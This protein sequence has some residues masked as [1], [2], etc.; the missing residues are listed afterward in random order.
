MNKTRAFTKE[1]VATN[2]SYNPTSNR[3]R[4]AVACS[5]APWPMVALGDLCDLIRGVVY[6][7][8]DE[9]RDNGKKILRANNIDVDGIINLKEVKHVNKNFDDS[10]IL[11]KDDI[12]IC[13]AS[14]S[15]SHIGKVAFIDYDTDFYFGAFMGCIR[16]K[17][18]VSA[19]YMFQSLNS[20]NFN[21][22]LTEQISGTNINNLSKSILYHFK[23]PLP[24]LAEQ[25]AI[26]ALLQIWDIAI[27]KT[28]TLIA[29]KERQFAWLCQQYFT[30]K[31]VMKYSWVVHKIGDFVE[32]RKEREIPSSNA[33]LYSLT[34]E[35]GVTAKTDRY[36][37]EFLVK[38]KDTKT[39]KVV[40]PKD[41]VF[42]PSNLRWGAIA[43]SSIS[44]KVVLSPIY[45]VYR[46]LEEKIDSDFLG[47][48][49]TCR[50]Q[51]KV[52]ASKT[53]GTLIER[54]AVKADTFELCDI[55]VPPSKK[56]Q[57]SI[58]HIL[59]T[60]QKEINLLKAL[61]QK[62]RTQKRGLMQK[63]LTGIWRV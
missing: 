51:I 59:N 54:M 50:R 30:F 11:K 40:H 26:A 20:K 23:I 41:I 43:L 2:R 4:K 42:N 56:E 13:L 27:E 58:A 7:K 10:K 48:A 55:V 29:A 14:G 24:P 17:E 1:R 37:R 34:I 46:I 35:N 52:F 9:V 21:A 39:Y 19:N 15:K 57:K 32:K 49:L 28:N 5:S 36:D 44:H 47:F 8:M 38:E 12:F 25:K 61:V 60:A 16:T 63:L 31:N 22:Y 53:E 18:N 62:Y 45:E 33:P 6:T 3:Y